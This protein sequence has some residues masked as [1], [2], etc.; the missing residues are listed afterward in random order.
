MELFKSSS[1]SSVNK[2]SKINDPKGGSIE[3]DILIGSV[4]ESQ[5]IAGVISF[6]ASDDAAYINGINLPVDGG[7][8]STL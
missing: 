5:D 8:L 1:K 2:D 3:N 4:G 7:R 6:L